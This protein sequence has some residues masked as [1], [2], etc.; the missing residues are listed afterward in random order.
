MRNPI[1]TGLASFGMSSVVF[2]GPLLKVNPGFNIHK[3]VERHK[4]NS[5]DNY[6]EARIVR[7]FEQLCDDKEIELIIVNTP[8]PLHYNQARKALNAGKHVVVEKPFTQ[9]HEQ[10][11]EL[12]KI[13]RR[14]N[15]LLSVF[16][17]RRWDGDF[18]TV[19]NVIENKL[20]GRLVDFESHFDRYR[21]FIQE[22]TWKESANAGAGTL[23]NLG[24]HLIDQV[25]MLF[26]MPQSVYANIRINRNMGEVDDSFDIFLKYEEL[27]VNTRSSLLVREPGPRYILHGTD[28]SFLKWGIDP[29]EQALKD[30]KLPVNDEW[31][32]EKEEE[33][34]VLNSNVQNLHFKGRI[35]TIPGD[36]RL[37]YDNIYSCIREKAE[38]M[39][40]PEE[41]AEVIRIIEIARQ[42]NE[43]GREIKL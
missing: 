3:I 7:D 27:R 26:G 36:Y 34:G 12:I 17:N 20:L 38:L 6:P 42:S 43:E 4:D 37:F 22:N 18:L 32:K 11:L 40:K 13:A 31:G 24:S 39:V 35:E 33:W 25:L 8:D 29:Q 30:G 15:L 16:Q 21:N 41:A 9:T 10:A 2:H 14:N 19:K 1:K 28:G 5:T 23:F